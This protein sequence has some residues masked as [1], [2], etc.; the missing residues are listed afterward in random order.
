MNRSMRSMIALAA[1]LVVACVASPSAQAHGTTFGSVD[2]GEI[3]YTL[4]TQYTAAFDHAKREWHKVGPIRLRPD[5]S[6]TINDLEISDVKKCTASWVG[7]WMWG[8]GAD[9][10]YL[11]RCFLDG[12]PKQQRQTMVHE[13]GHALGLGHN[14]APNI[15]SPSLSGMTSDVPL[16]HDREDYEDRMN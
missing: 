8:I 2:D 16:K 5:S 12:H 4:F 3:R 10:L 7:L 6:N 11:N 1:A 15:M 13:I 9:S 14:N